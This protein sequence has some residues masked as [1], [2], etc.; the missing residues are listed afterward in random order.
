MLSD[1]ETLI[2][3]SP[4]LATKL[5]IRFIVYKYHHA[6]IPQIDL[7][8]YMIQIMFYDNVHVNK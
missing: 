3:A 4:L 5:H 6:Y 8:P 7:D 1:T 2:C